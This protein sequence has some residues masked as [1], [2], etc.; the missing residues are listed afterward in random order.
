MPRADRLR[1]FAS[2]S[3][4]TGLPRLGRVGLR[5]IDCV[6][7]DGVTVETVAVNPGDWRCSGLMAYVLDGWMAHRSAGVDSRYARFK[8]AQADRYALD[9]FA[10][11]V[12]AHA[13]DPVALRLADVS[14]DLVSDAGLMD[15]TPAQLHALKAIICHLLGHQYRDV[16]AYGAGW[17]DQDRQQPIGNTGRHEPRQIDDIL[18]AELQRAI[19]DSD[20][21]RGIA[22]LTASWAAVVRTGPR[23]RHAHQ[24]AGHRSHG[25]RKLADAVPGGHRPLRAA[26]F[27]FLRPMLSP[28]LVSLHRDTFAFDEPLETSVELAA[29]RAES[30]LA[31]LNLGDNAEPGGP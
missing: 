30:D 24:A 3:R 21:L 19:E 6:R 13:V 16:I 22:H 31:E 17:T 18:N 2:R 25:S 14:L 26:V 28:R 11:F 8:T 29:H 7:P 5:A 9:D 10:R 20:P 4:L 15:P 1:S 23:R 12:D 27:G